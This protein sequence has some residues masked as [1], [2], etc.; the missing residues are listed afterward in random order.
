MLATWRYMLLYSVKDLKQGRR[1]GFQSESGRAM[2]HWQVLSTTMVG[3]PEK[4]LN[5]R[6][7]RMAKTVTF[8][9]W[10]HPFNSFCFES[11]SFFP[12]FPFF[13]FATQKSGVQRGVGGRGGMPAPPDPPVS[14]LALLRFPAEYFPFIKYSLKNFR[15]L[16]I[17][18]TKL[19]ER[20]K[21]FEP[22]LLSFFLT[23]SSVASYMS[24]D[25]TKWNSFVDILSRKSYD[26]KIQQILNQFMVR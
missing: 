26:M 8:W 19:F 9:P 20:N 16:N 6:R 18:Q 10:R 3:Q 11:L 22:N 14:P 4:C 5:S 2:K 21:N 25:F 24:T 12:L 15:V 13:V 23:Q 17:Y 7:S 1:N